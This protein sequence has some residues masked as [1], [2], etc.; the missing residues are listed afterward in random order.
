MNKQEFLEKWGYTPIEGYGGSLFDFRDHL[1]KD[2]DE[3]ITTD[4]SD[5]IP[6]AVY[7][8]GHDETTIIQMYHDWK[9]NPNWDDSLIP[10]NL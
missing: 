2:L 10:N 3:L 4:S 7:L 5:I 1:E 9:Q 6:F 8:T